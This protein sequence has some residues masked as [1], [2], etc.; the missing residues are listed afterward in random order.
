MTG[1]SV[2]VKHLCGRRQGGH[3]DQDKKEQHK[4][5]LRKASK[6]LGASSTQLV[7]HRRA[8]NNECRKPTKRG[9]EIPGSTRAKTCRGASNAKRMEEYVYS[10]FCFGCESWSWSQRWETNGNEPT[11]QKGRRNLDWALCKGFKI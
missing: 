1:K 8:W 5:P 3:D 2:V 10:V 11:V 9:G 6:F 4:V 7:N